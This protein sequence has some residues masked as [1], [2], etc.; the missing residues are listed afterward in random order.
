MMSEFL[1]EAAVLV[2]V[3]VP[4]DWLFADKRDVLTGSD[5]VGIFGGAGLLL[6]LGIVLERLRKP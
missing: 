5:M 6:A 1:R 3:F 2:F 4:L